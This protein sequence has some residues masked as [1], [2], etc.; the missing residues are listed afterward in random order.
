MKA[1]LI[2]SALVLTAA[3][4]SSTPT[5]PSQQPAQ[6]INVAGTWRGAYASAQI[7]YGRAT[8]S[9]SQTSLSVSGNWSTTPDPGGGSGVGAGTVSGTLT[10]PVGGS[11]QQATFTFTPSDP[12][13]CPFQFTGT[14]SPTSGIFGQWVA[15]NCSVTASGTLT[16]ER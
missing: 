1:I 4:S 6:G 9:L 7:G 12:R 10:S 5:S 11:S 8:L 2:I 13:N 3:C 14:A 16:L 15:T